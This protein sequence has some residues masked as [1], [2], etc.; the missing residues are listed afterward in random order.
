M[1]NYIE[2]AKRKLRSSITQLCDT[3]WMFVKDPERDFTRKRKLPLSGSD[4]KS[5]SLHSPLC[6]T[7]LSSRQRQYKGFRLF[8]A[9]GSDIQVPTNPD[10]TGSYF[11]GSKDQRPYNPLH[12]DAVYDLLQHTYADAELNGKRGFDE[13]EVLRKMADRSPAHNVIVIAGRDYENYNLM[14]HIQEKGWKYLIRL[15][16]AIPDCP[17]FYFR[18]F[19]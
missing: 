11:S 9:D 19:L 14:A 6:S 12:L 2:S 7:C 1:S 8:A 18:K 4:R 5:M 17:L 13:S 16:F 3:S 10:D 15:L